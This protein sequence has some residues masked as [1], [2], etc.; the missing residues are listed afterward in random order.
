MSDA[1]ETEAGVVFVESAPSEPERDFDQDAPLNAYATDATEDPTHK[2]YPIQ[3][4]DELG[5]LLA[6]VMREHEL[7]VDTSA[8]NALFLIALD[9]RVRIINLIQKEMSALIRQI[10][11]VRR[12]PAPTP[13]DIYARRDALLERIGDLMVARSKAPEDQQ[14]AIHLSLLERELAG[15]QC[16]LPDPQ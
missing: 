9:Q 5:E 3:T 12:P 6:G 7:K 13:Q 8:P 15:T 1:V 14:I 10:A 11:Q 16:I 4:A 2:Q